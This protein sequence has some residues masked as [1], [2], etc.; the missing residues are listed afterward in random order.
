MFEIE[1]PVARFRSHQASMNV[2]GGHVWRS[3]ES[4]GYQGLIA[5]RVR[6][7]LEA[8]GA[9]LPLFAASDALCLQVDF[10]YAARRRQLPSFEYRIV[11]PDLDNMLKLVKDA[12]EGLLFVD[13]A[14]ICRLESQKL[15][16]A[17]S[18]ENRLRIRVDRLRD[19]AGLL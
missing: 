19:A 18:S 10:L 2:R 1:I 17:G 9:S 5:R 12:L 15:H 13:D 4:H 8:S 7:S 11:R 14:Q 6:L 16:A 3:S